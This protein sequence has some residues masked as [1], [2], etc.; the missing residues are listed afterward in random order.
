M[1]ETP[2]YTKD[3]GAKSGNAWMPPTHA[4]VERRWS[5]R[6]VYALDL[7]VQHMARAGTHAHVVDIGL[8]GMRFVPS[9]SLPAKVKLIHLTFG[10]HNEFEKAH[11]LRAIVVHHTLGTYGVKFLDYD[12]G[13]FRRTEEIIKVASYAPCVW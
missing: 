2:D 12:Q 13:L 6:Q 3:F 7:Q 9:Q 1:L 10:L 4:M 5:V 11:E 8:E